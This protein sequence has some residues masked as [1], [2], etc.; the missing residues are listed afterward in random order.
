MKKLTHWSISVRQQWQI[1]NISEISYRVSGCIYG[2][3]SIK[4]GEYFFGGSDIQE[5]VVTNEEVIIRTENSAYYCRLKDAFWERM[6]KELGWLFG[7]QSQELKEGLTV[8]VDYSAKNLI[9]KI[10]HKDSANGSLTWTLAIPKPRN[11]RHL[12]VT[13]G[14]CVASLDM[15]KR[16]DYAHLYVTGIEQRHV[17]N[18]NWGEVTLWI[19][20]DLRKLQP[21][22]LVEF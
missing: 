21:D 22:E 9:R 8:F 17:K 18:A 15:V 14:E 5:I 7:L 19:E 11:P 1:P 6:D 12:M 2:H 3:E 16:G 13:C 4:D 10:C 20:D